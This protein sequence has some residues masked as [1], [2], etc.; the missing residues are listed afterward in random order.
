MDGLER[1]KKRQE[2]AEAA[3]PYPKPRGRAPRGKEWDRLAGEWKPIDLPATIAEDSTAV[4]TMAE[5]SGALAAVVS[6][7]PPLI[8]EH[9]RE[10][11][12][13]WS[14]D[15]LLPGRSHLHEQCTPGGSRAHTF[16]H[17]SPGGTAR[18][19][20]YTSPA[21]VRATGEQR[22]DLRLRIVRSRMQARGV[23]QRY[24]TQ[25]T[26]CHRTQ[27]IMPNGRM[28]PHSLR[29]TIPSAQ[30][31]AYKIE[32]ADREDVWRCPGSHVYYGPETEDTVKARP[33]VNVRRF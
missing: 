13:G 3:G 14:V 6:W 20:Q 16:D 11:H 19:E 9:T 33:L 26:H 22:C 28:F 4:T 8:W 25:C 32:H 7:E 15:H 21:E 18:V 17:T 10:D 1:R 5:D 30:R 23:V 27:H 12:S 24:W 2:R 31:A 29:E